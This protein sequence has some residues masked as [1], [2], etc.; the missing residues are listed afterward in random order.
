MQLLRIGVK[1]SYVDI[2]ELAK[3]V[4]SRLAKYFQENGYKVVFVEL[5]FQL[6]NIPE[7]DMLIT[8]GEILGENSEERLRNLRGNIP[9]FHFIPWNVYPPSVGYFYNS[10]EDWG[11]YSDPLWGGAIIN[12][13]GYSNIIPWLTT[14]QESNTYIIAGMVGTAEGWEGFGQAYYFHDWTNNPE[15]SCDP[16]LLFLRKY[17]VEM[18]PE[19]FGNLSKIRFAFDIEGFPMAFASLSQL[20]DE[21]EN[22]YIIEFFKEAI[23]KGMKFTCA[24]AETIILNEKVIEEIRKYIKEHYQNFRLHIYMD[25]AF[26][27]EIHDF[28]GTEENY[29]KDISKIY[30]VNL[31]DLL[32]RHWI[33]PHCIISPSMAEI[34]R[35][36]DVNSVNATKIMPYNGERES[37][38]KEVHPIKTVDTRLRNLYIYGSPRLGVELN[39]YEE[40][41]DIEDLVLSQTKA[42]VYNETP[43]MDADNFHM[44][45]A[46]EFPYGWRVFRML[47]NFLSKFD[48]HYEY[49]FGCQKNKLA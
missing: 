45:D 9:I 10:D 18:F 3:L 20:K 24:I 23:S 41:Y 15:L 38:L 44:H 28:Q 32:G 47:W 8:F 34:L 5:P 1:I 13:E 40:A 33:A 19:Q 14:N 16:G 30:Q 26:Q 11:Y 4:C 6:R 39:G 42:L 37:K 7:V 46:W 31:Q 12:V 17:L 2:A 27:F 49:V 22:I 29:L 43:F 48:G 36:Y 35:K 25:F 21:N